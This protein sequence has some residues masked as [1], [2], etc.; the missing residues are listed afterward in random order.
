ME[1]WIDEDLSLLQLNIQK[2]QREYCMSSLDE[3]SYMSNNTWLTINYE[4]NVCLNSWY[5]LF[6][7]NS[8]R[9]KQDIRSESVSMS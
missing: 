9:N 7:T 6:P 1:E 5:H 4:T 3:H 8:Y 2:L